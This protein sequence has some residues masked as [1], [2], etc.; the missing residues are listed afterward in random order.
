[1]IKIKDPKTFEILANKII[2]AIENAH[3][4]VPS[5]KTNQI[6]NQDYSVNHKGKLNAIITSIMNRLCYEEKINIIDLVSEIVV[7]I[8]R[9]HI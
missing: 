9:A 2:E 5:I 6:E 8:A 3:K 7:R 1:M 4:L